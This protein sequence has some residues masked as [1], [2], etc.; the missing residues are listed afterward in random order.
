MSLFLEIDKKNVIQL[1]TR[2]AFK[3]LN[4]ASET[5]VLNIQMVYFSD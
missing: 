2:N 5:K 4:L 3:W 1:A